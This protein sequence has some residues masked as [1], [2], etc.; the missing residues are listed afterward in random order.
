MASTQNLAFST[1]YRTTEEIGSFNIIKKLLLLKYCVR[2][3]K[4]HS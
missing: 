1:K 3:E 2:E 4:D